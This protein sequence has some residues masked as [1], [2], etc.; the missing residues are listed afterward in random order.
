MDIQFAVKEA[1]RAMGAPQKKHWRMLHKVGRYLLG[2]PRMLIK[3][4]WQVE[5]SMVTTF[6]DSD[7]AGCKR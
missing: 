4:P 3:F 2:A 1:A 5:Q 6:T 7:W